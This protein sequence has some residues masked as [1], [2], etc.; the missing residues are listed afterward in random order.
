MTG[1]CD[2][3]HNNNKCCCCGELV[4]EDDA[5]VI[6]EQIKN[7]EEN[8]MWCAEDFNLTQDERDV[9]LDD[10]DMSAIANKLNEVRYHRTPNEIFDKHGMMPM[11]KSIFKDGEFEKNKKR[12]I[13][14]YY[15]IDTDK[16]K[17][18]PGYADKDGNPYDRINDAIPYEE[19]RVND[20]AYKILKFIN[21][22]PNCL[23]ATINK[24]VRASRVT[25]LKKLPYHPISR[26]YASKLVDCESKFIGFVDLKALV[27][28]SPSGYF[29]KMPRFTR[30]YIITPHGKG[31]L[32]ELEKGKRKEVLL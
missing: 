23:A 16:E 32:A 26:L 24:N 31:V 8:C 22:N 12:A 14:M 13:Q 3:L 18:D 21:Q 19:I 20:L 6:Y 4:G 1:W 2:S 15:G 7:C 9:V 25:K 10:G 27:E 11:D 28:R 30:K 17:F 29:G 5:K